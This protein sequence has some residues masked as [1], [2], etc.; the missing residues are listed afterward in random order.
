MRLEEYHHE[1]LLIMEKRDLTPIERQELAAALAI[2]QVGAEKVDAVNASEKLRLV[3]A[4]SAWAIPLRT[5]TSSQKT[6]VVPQ[7]EGT[8]AAVCAW[9]RMKHASDEPAAPRGVWANNP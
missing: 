9:P 7:P 6:T 3:N 8:D 5:Q 4:N 2:E 1:F